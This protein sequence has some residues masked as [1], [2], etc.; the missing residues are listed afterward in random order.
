MRISTGTLVLASFMAMAGCAVTDDAEGSRPAETA[1]AQSS[2]ATFQLTVTSVE[3]DTLVSSAAGVNTCPLK[4]TCSFTYE[5][6]T[7][8]AIDVKTIFSPANDC[9]RFARWTGACAGQGRP[10]SVTITDSNLAVSSIW[11]LRLHC[12]PD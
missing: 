5:A 9:V 2:A 6:G 11:Q 4:S 8:L 10:C 1:V 7:A 3:T 12:I